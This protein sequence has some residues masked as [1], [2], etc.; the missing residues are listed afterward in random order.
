M[1]ALESPPHLLAVCPMQTSVSINRDCD[2]RGFLFASHIGWCM[3]RLIGRLHDGRYDPETTERMLPRL[4]AWLKD[5][6]KSQL[7][8]LPLSSM[9]ALQDT[10]FP[11]LKD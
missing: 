10:P 5:Y 6:P 2:N 4:L 3:S 1:A 9:P 7:S 11:L 8:A